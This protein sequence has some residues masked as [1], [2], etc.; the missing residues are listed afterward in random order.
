[1]LHAQL[2]PPRLRHFHLGY[3]PTREFSFRFGLHTD[4]LNFIVKAFHA[5]WLRDLG[6]WR[7]A[8]CILL[9]RFGFLPFRFIH[10]V[11]ARLQG[12]IVILRLRNDAIIFNFVSS[13]FRVNGQRRIHAFVLTN[14]QLAERLRHDENGE[15]L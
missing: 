7:H 5:M 15:H 13:R 14:R 1:M 4:G 11:A 12:R 10:D 3:D 9:V 8:A 6:V 2:R